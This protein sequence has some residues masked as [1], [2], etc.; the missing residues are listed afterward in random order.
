MAARHVVV[1]GSG[2]VGLC[3]AYYLLERGCRVT[4]V[5]RGGPDRD[6]CSLGNA[7]Y[8]SPSHVI[9]LPSPGIVKKALGWMGDPESPFYVRPRLDPAFLG[10]AWRFWRAATPD[11]ARRAGPVLRDLTNQS[12][13][14]YVALAERAG[15]DFELATHGLLNL[16]RTPQGLAE[17]THAAEQARALGV[18][19]EMLDARG[20][21]A[22][23]PDVRLD[24]IGGAFYPTDAH[25]TPQR[26]VATL[27]R[28]VR[29]AGAAFTW[30][31]EILGWRN[32]GRAIRAART[33]AGEVEAD[34]FVLA[35]GSWTPR[36]AAPL[37]VSLPMEPGKGYSVTIPESPVPLRRSVLLHEA[38]VAITP[39]GR[40]LR[41]GGTMELTGYDLSI[42]PP[43]IRGIRKS[44]RRFL[45]EIRED[46]FDGLKPWCGL[47]PC[48]PDGLP[49]IGRVGRY[50]NLSVAAG[51]AMMGLSMAPATG[52]LLA[53]ILSGEP[54]SVEPTLLH[55]DRYV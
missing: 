21:A 41:I 52:R 10:W 29:D 1:V 33:A 28:W 38:R 6:N 4:V 12:R 55:P 53:Q 8:I 14:I 18:P 42:N 22:L 39:M 2:V 9:P 36:L 50:A 27:E 54:P 11:W 30:N 17:E 37:G 15:N 19:A 40:S 35:A 51:H 5:E 23:E 45:P 25:L 44:L 43:R 24:V 7:G 32:E 31:A 3:C 46:A 47:R 13:E 34:E 16:V 20:V 49:Y 48:T 26:F